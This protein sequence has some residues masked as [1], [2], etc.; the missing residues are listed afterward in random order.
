MSSAERQNAEDFARMVSEQY[1][2]VEAERARTRLARVAALLDR[3]ARQANFKAC[4]RLLGD[5]NAMI[6]ELITAAR[7]ADRGSP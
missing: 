7:P 4:P 3:V 6:D 5:V 1:I 2:L